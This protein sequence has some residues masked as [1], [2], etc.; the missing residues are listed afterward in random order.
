[1]TD[2]SKPRFSF[3]LSGTDIPVNE[4]SEIWTAFLPEDRHM[5]RGGR[6]NVTYGGY[7]S[8]LRLYLEK[9]LCEKIRSVV[10]EKTG[11]G[12]NASDIDEIRVSLQKHGAFYHPAKIDVHINGM[13]R[14]FVL[15]AAISET[16]KGCVKRECEA[17]A[18]LASDP[19]P[20][21]LPRIYDQGEIRTEDGRSLSFFLGEWFNGY[22]ELHLSRD[23]EDD[24]LKL[25]VWDE[26]HG[27]FFLSPGQ[28]SEFYERAAFILTCFYDLETFEQVFPWHHA[29]GDFIIRC[30]GGL[31]VKL[32]TVR[33][34]AAM[35]GVEKND[36][37]SA[38]YVMEGALFFL[39]SISVRMRLDRIDGTGEIAWAGDCAAGGVL[40][41]FMKALA[42]KKLRASPTLSPAEGFISFISSRSPGDHFAGMADK[43][44]ENILFFHP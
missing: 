34:R 21:F 12:I 19:F 1:M 5:T 29:A 7:F 22:S 24:L 35:F 39:L 26:E 13:A 3:F 10:S 14:S 20:G 8:G 11:S 6:Y 17:I 28:E 31:D 32:V 36:A 43:N 37:G 38:D 23:P 18:K 41:G 16:G 25:M 9:K 30:G 44:L 40:K 33:Q 27:R 2:N 4:K 15:N 42:L